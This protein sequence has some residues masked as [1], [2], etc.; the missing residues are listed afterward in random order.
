VILHQVRANLCFWC[1]WQ[2]SCVRQNRV[3]R[4]NPIFNPTIV[5]LEWTPLVPTAFLSA[6]SLST[7]AAIAHS[8][9]WAVPCKSIISHL[10]RQDQTQWGMDR[11]GSRGS[12]N[13]YL[14]EAVANV[15]PVIAN[16][17]PDEL[18][19]TFKMRIQL[20][21][22]FTHLSSF[23]LHYKQQGEYLRSEQ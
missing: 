11:F 12:M 15:K 2:Y 23:L 18:T 22:I 13:T 1:F 6:K 10:S 8:P 3:Q 4:F 19:T 20:K 14:S 5:V 21:L 17:W 7:T 9:C 16:A